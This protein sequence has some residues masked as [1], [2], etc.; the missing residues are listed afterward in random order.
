M[1]R[2][3]PQPH[4]QSPTQTS[5]SCVLLALLRQFADRIQRIRRDG[6]TAQRFGGGKSITYFALKGLY[7]GQHHPH[8]PNTEG[9]LPRL[10]ALLSRCSGKSTAPN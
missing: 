1:P 8:W 4:Q 9:R 5:I 3:I 6:M 10:L 2:I 7:G